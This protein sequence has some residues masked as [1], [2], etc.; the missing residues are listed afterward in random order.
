M[1]KTPQGVTGLVFSSKNPWETFLSLMKQF[2][3]RRV[4]EFAHGST[5]TKW[6][7]RYSNPGLSDYK[8]HA[9]HLI[10]ILW[11]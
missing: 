4:K 10:S 6:R 3:L 9:A 8:P 2:K 7:S 1:T 11:K 5:V